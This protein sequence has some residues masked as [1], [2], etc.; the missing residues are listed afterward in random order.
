M[1]LNIK[2]LDVEAAVGK[3]ARLTRVSKTEA[4]RRAVTRE[5]EQIEPDLVR[6]DRIRLAKKWLEEEVWPNLP[7]GVLGRGVTKEEREKILGYGPDGV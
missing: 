1:G 3:L 4:V 5:L 7:P 2:A 6:E